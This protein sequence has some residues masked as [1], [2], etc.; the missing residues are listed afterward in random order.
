MQSSVNLQ[1]KLSG[2]NQ[3]VLVPSSD[4]IDN[5]S[6]LKRYHIQLGLPSTN[7][8]LKFINQSKMTY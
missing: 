7:L 2:V 1:L 8:A 4:N 5:Y 6:M 3:C